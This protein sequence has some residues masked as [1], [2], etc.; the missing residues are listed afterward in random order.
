MLSAAR[1]D[2]LRR[3]LPHEVFTRHLAE[4]QHEDLPAPLHTFGEPRVLERAREVAAERLRFDEAWRERADPQVE[5]GQRAERVQRIRDATDA[6]APV[7]VRQTHRQ[8][9]LQGLCAV[10]HARAVRRPR[11]HRQARRNGCGQ[12]RREAAQ[13]REAPPGGG[14]EGFVGVLARCLV[15]CWFGRHIGRARTPR[16]GFGGLGHFGIS[17][18]PHELGAAER[19][20]RLRGGATEHHEV[21]GGVRGLRIQPL[22]AG[23]VGAR[24]GGTGAAGAACTV[25]RAMQRHA[26]HGAMTHLDLRQVVRRHARQ[27]ERHAGAPRVEP[28]R[29]PA[30]RV[31]RRRPRPRAHAEDGARRAPAFADRRAIQQKPGRRHEAVVGVVPADAKADVVGAALGR[32]GQLKFGL[33]HHVASDGGPGGARCEAVSSAGG[34]WREPASQRSNVKSLGGS[35]GSAPQGGRKRAPIMRSFSV[36]GVA[37]LVEQRIR[38]A[39][40]GSSTLFTGTTIE[41]G[42]ASRGPCCLRQAPAAGPHAPRQST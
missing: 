42:P 20:P 15:R 4:R 1:A 7:G 29:Q 27:V 9:H 5:L 40:V 3:E 34:S 28:Q 25:G 19:G 41:T 17:C 11:G 8:Q 23:R 30:P 36:A 33:M 24:E 10:E 37:Q 13:R 18:T 38:N 14:G 2:L 35:P 22:D 21:A 16:R 39:K 6:R 31:S 26:P 32:A 12:R